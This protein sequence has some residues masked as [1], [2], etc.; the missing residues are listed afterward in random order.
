M[1]RLKQALVGHLLSII[2]VIWFFKPVPFVQ[3]EKVRSWSRDQNLN[4]KITNIKHLT[5]Y[6]K[7]K[8]NFGRYVGR[9]EYALQHG[10]QYT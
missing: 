1:Q 10:G 6:I 8:S 7:A 2:I 5:R 9:Q 3:N 4:F